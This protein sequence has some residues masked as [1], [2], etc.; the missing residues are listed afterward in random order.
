MYANIHPRVVQYSALE[1]SLV[2]TLPKNVI[3][4]KLLIDNYNI[5]FTT[6]S[7][8]PSLSPPCVNQIILSSS[9]EDNI[10]T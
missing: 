8:S 1:L 4:A 6:K 2:F 3:L 9:Y 10:L 7:S 5:G